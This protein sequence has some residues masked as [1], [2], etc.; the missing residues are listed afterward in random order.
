[1][2]HSRPSSPPENGPGPPADPKVKAINVH[3]VIK[4]HSSRGS[5]NHVDSPRVHTAGKTTPPRV[6]MIRIAARSNGRKVEVEEAANK[7][8]STWRPIQEVLNVD[9]VL[10]ELEHSAAGSND[11]R[12]A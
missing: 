1:M 7:S 6:T 5:Q 10:N 2:A 4:P 11:S 8:K 12:G 9:T 3:E